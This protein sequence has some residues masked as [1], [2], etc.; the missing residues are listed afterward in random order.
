MMADLTTDTLTLHDVTAED[1]R[2]LLYVCSISRDLDDAREL[3]DALGL[4]GRPMNSSGAWKWPSM[5][6]VCRNGHRG[7]PRYKNGSCVLCT[8]DRNAARPNRRKAARA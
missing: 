3:I 2:V 5:S 8:K 1:L 7:P 6:D 4:N